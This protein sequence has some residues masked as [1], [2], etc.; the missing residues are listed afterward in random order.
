M[1]SHK[2]LDDESDLATGADASDYSHP[3]VALAPSLLP[4]TLSPFP[5]C[6][7]KHLEKSDFLRVNRP[8]AVHQLL[9]FPSPSLFSFITWF[10][11]L[12]ICL[13]FGPRAAWQPLFQSFCPH[14]S[15]SCLFAHQRLSIRDRCVHN[16]DILLAVSLWSQ[17]SRTGRTDAVMSS[18]TARKYTELSLSLYVCLEHNY[19]SCLTQI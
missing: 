5:V 4:F 9:R 3:S 7:A 12:S 17:W 11:L 10:L 19:K 8:T 18:L 6:A 16:T 1:W 14:V 15:V 13:P 2:I